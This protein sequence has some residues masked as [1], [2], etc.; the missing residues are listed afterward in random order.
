MEQRSITD[1]TSEV[2]IHAPVKGATINLLASVASED[3]VSIHAPVKGA[4]IG[5]L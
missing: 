2:S 5:M 3:D 4:T 1:L